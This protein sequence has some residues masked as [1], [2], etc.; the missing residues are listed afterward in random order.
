MP[1]RKLQGRHN[2][3]EGTLP[4]YNFK[5]GDRVLVAFEE[6]ITQPGISRFQTKELVERTDVTTARAWKIGTIDM[7]AL[8]GES[9]M[10]HVLLDKPYRRKVQ[11]GWVELDRLQP[12]IPEV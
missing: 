2:D 1:L 12:Y 9:K 8:R 11:R 3:F 10:Y 6:S 5:E 4:T 7:I